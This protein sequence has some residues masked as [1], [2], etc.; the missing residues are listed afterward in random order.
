M[1]GTLLEIDA[2]YGEGG[3]QLVR[4]AVALAAITGTPIRLRAVRARRTP[5]GLAPQHVAAIRSV[6]SICAGTCEGLALRA[7]S[8]DFIPGP[9]VGGNYR[10][11]IGT[12][13]SITL[14]LQALV[15]VMLRADRDSRVRVIGGTDIRAAPPADYFRLVLVELLRRMG[16]TISMVIHRRGYY[17]RG[18]GEVEVTVAP[19]NL[20]AFHA[21]SAGPLLGI[22]GVVHVGNLPV[23]IAQR[24]HTTARAALVE[25]T[26]SKAGGSIDIAEQVLGR[27]LAIGTGGAVVLRARTQATL[28]GAGRVAERGVP[29]ETLGTAAGQELAG[30][31]A[32]GAT[33]DLH[34]ADQMLVY[35]AMAD[36]ASEF[37]TRRLSSH[38]TTAMWLIQQF[39]PASVEISQAAGLTHV[40]VQPRPTAQPQSRANGA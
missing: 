2:A 37:R 18:G 13:G 4:T 20:R 33:L 9:I 14:L 34:A 12:A 30:D 28:L 31:L 15:P 23:Q 6:A 5:P 19:S 29:A 3:G 39:L 7:R 10:F 24:M 16:A 26:G 40:R 25:A 8:F 22:D 32:S 35:C 36:G 38:A 27:E 11:D 1:N 17:P 21:A